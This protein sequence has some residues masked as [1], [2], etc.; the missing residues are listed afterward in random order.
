[1]LTIELKATI[2]S[3]ILFQI[4]ILFLINNRVFIKNHAKS[5]IV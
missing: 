5:I 2:K 4:Q 1:M 3:M